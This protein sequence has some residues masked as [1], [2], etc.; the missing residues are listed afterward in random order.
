MIQKWILTKNGAIIVLEPISLVSLNGPLETWHLY[1]WWGSSLDSNKQ[2]KMTLDM[3][4]KPFL[5]SLH[6]TRWSWIDVWMKARH[7]TSIERGKCMSN[8]CDPKVLS[9]TLTQNP[10]I[11]DRCLNGG[12]I[13]R[14]Y[15]YMTSGKQLKGAT[16][17]NPREYFINSI[18]IP[19]SSTLYE[20]LGF[21]K[22]ESSTL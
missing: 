16:R 22:F 12:L 15:D 13:T 9:I 5:S 3:I 1:V 21:L 8:L 10:E 14:S 7:L 11:L 17:L 19:T 2:K 20:T 6:K 4:L 18:W